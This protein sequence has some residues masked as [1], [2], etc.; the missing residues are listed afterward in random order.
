M[1]DDTA[2]KL[3]VRELLATGESY[4][5]PEYQR[6]YAWTG[7]EIGQLIEDVHLA[8]TS[9]RGKYFLGNI[10]TTRT[11]DVYEVVDGQ[12]RLTTLVLLLSALRI[13]LEKPVD[14]VSTS[15]HALSFASRPNATTALQRIAASTTHEGALEALGGSIRDSEGAET[16]KR[17]PRGAVQGMH[18][19]YSAIRAELSN[20][21]FGHS[22][23]LEA[24]HD[25][26][27]NHVEMIRVDLPRGTDLN[28]Y[29]EVMNTRGV[30][31]D[32]ADIVRAQLMSALTGEDAELRTFQQVWDACAQMEGFVQ[33]ALT[34]S[35]LDLRTN[36]FG[37]HWRWLTATSFE[38]LTEHLGGSTPDVYAGN[39]G[40]ARDLATALEQYMETNVSSADDEDGPQN[41]Q[42][43]PTVRFPFLLLHSLALFETSERGYAGTAHS[44]EA[45]DDKRA[46]NARDATEDPALD[47]KQLIEAFST[48]FPRLSG[49]KTSARDSERVRRFALHLLRVRNLFDAYIIRR[50]QP[51]PVTGDDDGTWA[52]KSFS[53]EG[54]GKN[55][56]ARYLDTFGS[57]AENDESGGVQ[58]VSGTRSDQRDLVLLESML[59]VTYTSPRSMRWITDVLRQALQHHFPTPGDTSSSTAVI[60][61]A[62]PARGLS[63]LLR[64]FTRERIRSS[65]WGGD[66]NVPGDLDFSD[67]RALPSGFTIP[68]IV[69]TYLDY[70]LLDES[71]GTIPS[72]AS[73]FKPVDS[74]SFVFRFRNSVEHFAPGTRDVETDTGTVSDAWKQ[75]LGNLALI[76]V[77]QNSKFSN[78]SPQTK[79]QSSDEVLQQSPKLW[80]MAYL[81]QTTG[82]WNDAEIQHHHTECLALLRQDLLAAVEAN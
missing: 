13:E 70:L 44:S 6:N 80:R 29:F 64:N 10:V 27:L 33:I 78:A 66:D 68:R 48:A 62:L 15:P 47:D 28:R 17:L 71:L 54:S 67:P 42:Y 52:L 41:R 73:R 72:T 39:H 2:Q 57:R 61:T 76:T 21:R 38:E 24:F 77:R 11:K 32:P 25:Y 35:K 8:C 49:D 81:T 23:D 55:R 51:G 9:K 58:P 40:G 18:A 3:T 26:L 79:S 75:S 12:Q 30:Q 50:Y 56:T 20:P 5:I 22:G 31:L 7:T 53:V 74:A 4:R 82:G 45:D 16:S 43:H 65:F 14:V 19:G 46:T 1:T 59:R 36:L 69:F 34:P 60:T 63:T 37:K